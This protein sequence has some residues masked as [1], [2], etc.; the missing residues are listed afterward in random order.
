MANDDWRLHLR[1]HG[2]GLAR[3]L[4]ER[5]DAADLEHDLERAFHDRVIVSVDGP[6]LYA[7]TG[8]R[9]QADAA[10]RLI[11]ELEGDREIE[12]SLQR[13]HPS[14]QA[15]EDPD[16]PLPQ[17]DAD[18]LAER[19]Q[20]IERERAESQERGYPEYEVRVESASREDAAALASKLEGQGLPVVH[21]DRY[22]VLGASDEDAATALA[23]QVRSLAPDGATVTA[24]ASIRAVEDEL[25][26]NPFAIFGGLGG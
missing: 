4:V 26:P 23:D 17:S 13:W 12:L 19:A 8:S 10:A 6:D 15:W 7:Y 3:G 5:L 9:E 18:E 20:R 11:R 25:G 22:L 2:H 21:R 1:L 24:Q 14:A 16:V